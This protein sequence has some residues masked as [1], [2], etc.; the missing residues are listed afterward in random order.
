MHHGIDEPAVADP[1]TGA[2][3]GQQIRGLG[4]GLH[5][6]GNH[7]VGVAGVD[8]QVGEVDGIESGQ[9]DLVDGRCSHTHWD[10]GEVGGLAGSD[11]PSAG[12]DDLAHKDVVD[13]VRSHPGPLEGGGD[14]EATQ[15]SGGKATE[16]ARQLA[17]RGAGSCDDDGSGHCN[18]RGLMADSGAFPPR[19]RRDDRA[20]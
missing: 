5:A 8:H 18:L 15:L 4:H 7:D 13:L 2:S 16:R 17:D 11:L 12:L 19:A 6:A 3:A 10:P 9:A 20:P 14:G 1:V